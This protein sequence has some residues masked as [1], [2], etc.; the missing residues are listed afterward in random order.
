MELDARSGPFLSG[1]DSR[2]QLFGAATH[3]RQESHRKWMRLGASRRADLGAFA[4]ANKRSF[5]VSSVHR[6]QTCRSC[7][8]SRLMK[9]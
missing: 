4:A 3:V 1:S 8:L 2:C 7:L 6:K 5:L 9:L